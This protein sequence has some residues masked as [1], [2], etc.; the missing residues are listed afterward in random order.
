MIVV[1]TSCQAKFRIP[2]EKVGPKGAKVRCSKC[3]TVFVVKREPAAPSPAAPPDAGPFAAAAPSPV[4]ADPFAAATDPFAPGASSQPLA[5]PQGDPFAEAAA[6][7][8]ETTATHL[9]VTDLSDL[10]GVRGATGGGPTALAP[11][12]PPARPPPIPDLALAAQVPSAAPPPLPVAAP[13]FLGG[14]A[15]LSLEESSSAGTQIPGASD[16]AGFDPLESQLAPDAGESGLE[17]GGDLFQAAPP[18]PPTSPEITTE[19]SE[20][21]P[22]RPP[23]TAHAARPPAAAVRPSAVDDSAAPEPVA[24]MGRGRLRALLVNSFSLVA[25]LLVTVGLL[26]LSRG[27][28]TL[29]RRFLGRGEGAPAPVVAAHVTNGLYET[30]HG[31][32][33]LFVRGTVRSQSPAPL[34]PVVVR[35]EVVL[36]DQ[37]VARAEGIAGAVPTPE[38]LA[39]I[40]GQEDAERL[41]AALAPRSRREI[42]PGESVPFLITFTDYPPDLGEATFRVVAEPAPRG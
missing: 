15:G 13:P 7:P 38:E 11:P 14:D 28:G 35:A 27:E 12:L 22:P 19:V 23:R 4:E 31:R 32:K 42:R 30:A 24:D 41:R 34:G 18:E 17:L 40:T 25:L 6:A 29:A 39:A 10:A 37:V 16:F 8:G 21:E 3:K 9:P 2:D 5:P 26:M 33:L 36:G 1:C 20:P